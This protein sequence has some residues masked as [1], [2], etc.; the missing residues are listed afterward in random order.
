MNKVQVLMAVYGLACLAMILV[1]RYYTDLFQPK[2]FG[3]NLSLWYAFIPNL[4]LLAVG[5]LF[6]KEGK[7]LIS[8]I[9]IVLI[10]ISA[11]LFYYSW[12]YVSYE[13]L[14]GFVLIPVILLSFSLY[15]SLKK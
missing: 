3:F 8:I 11:Y 10:P 13:V 14:A 5:I 15:A 12:I 9:P 6:F 2:I 1:Y 7:K 4:M